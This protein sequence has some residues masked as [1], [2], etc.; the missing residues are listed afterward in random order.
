MIL[1]S[2]L[3]CQDHHRIILM[4]GCTTDTADHLTSVY[5]RK[6]LQIPLHGM[7][8]VKSKQVIISVK[9][10]QFCGHHLVHIDLLTALITD[11]NASRNDIQ[12][13]KYTVK[14]HGL[15]AGSRILQ[16]DLQSLCLIIIRINSRK[17][18][19]AVFTVTDSIV[20]VTHI[21]AHASVTIFQHQ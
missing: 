19:K 21:T 14:K 15:H 5:Y 11:I 13:R 7:S 9:K 8:S 2:V 12:F 20:L 10:I 6:P 4:T 1:C 3:F 16:Y 17:P 18:R